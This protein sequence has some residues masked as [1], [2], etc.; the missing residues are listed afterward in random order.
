MGQVVVT[1]D[2]PDEI[3]TVVDID[4]RDHL[5][6]V[7]FPCPGG[8]SDVMEFDPADLVSVADRPVT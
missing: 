7:R 1:L 3:G 4:E 2:D 8:L 5:V 6:C